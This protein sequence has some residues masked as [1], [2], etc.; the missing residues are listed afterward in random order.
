MG[1]LGDER[2]VDVAGRRVDVDKDGER[3]LVE[4]AVGG[5]DKGKG[6][7]DDQVRHA[8]LVGAAVADP[9]GDHAEVQAAGARVDADGVGGA[10]V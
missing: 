7:G 10:H 8:E 5:G 3:A 9:G 4:D 2:G 1:G 6:R